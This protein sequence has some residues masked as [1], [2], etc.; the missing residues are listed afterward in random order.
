MFGCILLVVGMAAVPSA[1]ETP[2]PMERAFVHNLDTEEDFTSIQEAIDD[3]DTLAGHTLSVEPG[4]YLENV[5]VNKSL[6]L[7]SASGNPSDTLVIAADGSLP[8]IEVESSFTTISGFMVSGSTMLAGLHLGRADSC[9]ISNNH[10]MGNRFG[11][12]VDH[13]SG[14]KVTK[15]TITNNEGHGMIIEGSPSTMLSDN[16]VNSNGFSMNEYSGMFIENSPSCTVERNSIYANWYAGIWLHS[17]D[18]AEVSD[19]TIEGN[20]YRGLRIEGST[21]GTFVG[22]VLIS[23]LYSLEV[24]GSTVDT[25]KHSMDQSNTVDGNPVYYWVNRQNERVPVDAGFV[26]IIDSSGIVVSDLQ[27]SYNHAGVL[28]A[29]TEDSTIENVEATKCMNGVYL[30]HS[31]GCTLR[32][33]ILTGNHD[34]GMRLIGSDGSVITG[35]EASETGFHSGCDGILVEASDGCTLADNLANGNYGSGLA[36]WGSHDCTLDNNTA[37]HNEHYGIHLNGECDEALCR[38]NRAEGNGSAGIHVFDSDHVTLKDN[39]A[40]NNSGSETS[41]GIRVTGGT[42]LLCFNNKTLSNDDHGFHL[43]GIRD[44]IFYFNTIEGNRG[45]GIAMN[46]GDGNLLFHNNIM[47]NTENASDDG[48]NAWDNGYPAGGNYF[49]D[50]EGEDADGD[51][52]GDAPHE[53]PDG[54]SL[55]RYPFMEPLSLTL[56]ADTTSLPAGSGGSVNFTLNAGE[57]Y[58]SRAYVILGTISGTLPGTPLP[59]G[60]AVLPVNWDLFTDNVLL[61]CN[62][63]VF[64]NFHGILDGAG[65]GWARIDTQTPLDPA[66]VGITME[67]AFC[68]IGW[69]WD[70][71]SNPVSIA[72]VP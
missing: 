32:N 16:E 63:P 33:N 38:N 37:Q 20:T 5:V 71:A 64:E 41:S 46:D 8:V 23:N 42:Y 61:L 30:F 48:T 67:Y 21:D 4:T 19:N 29:F 22:N 60:Q 6:N 35:N 9:T 49:S 58:G 10:C 59:G 11:L 26:G 70:F 40:E 55:D 45:I 36:L 56:F 53:I 47:D 12:H 43:I 27:L 54:S 25:Y 15:N 51:G 24:L 65:A 44:S 72:I 17:S 57:E 7:Q 3:L 66:F 2:I 52:I 50:Y 34:Y 39:K 18:Y 28:F 62:S 14:N 69:P 68:I 1:E 13:G 31:P